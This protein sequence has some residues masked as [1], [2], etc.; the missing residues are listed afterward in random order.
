[1]SQQP[2]ADRS[3]RTAWAADA[4]AI[5]RVQAR[6]WTKSYAEVLPQ[7]LLDQIDA[8]GFAEAWTQAITRPPSARH[9]VLVAL[10]A[11]EVVG[12][13]ATAPSDDQDAAPTDGEIVAFHIDPRALRQGHGSRL[14]AAA[15]DTLR[16]DGFTHAR[17]WAVVGDD[18][19]RGFLEPAGWAADTAHRTLDLTGDDSSTLRQVRLHTDLREDES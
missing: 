19:V 1:M 17:F 11:G 8:T 4:G 15:A 7:A 14:L 10:E 18:D 5:G 2:V 9:R 16:A 6:A 13:A 12:F 3:V